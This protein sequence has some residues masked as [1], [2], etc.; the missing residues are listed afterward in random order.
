MPRNSLV[1][2]LGNSMN[3]TVTKKRLVVSAF[4]CAGRFFGSAV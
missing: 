3:E 4:L 1:S 2:L